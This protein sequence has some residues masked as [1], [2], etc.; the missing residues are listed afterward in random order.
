MIP[1]YDATPEP[2]SFL[3]GPR[4][5]GPAIDRILH[6]YRES[7]ALITAV[8]LGLF[9]AFGKTGESC[10]G[11]SCTGESCTG[12]SCTGDSTTGVGSTIDE[13]ARHCRISAE[14]CAVLCEVL[15]GSGLLNPHLH[16]GATCYMPTELAAAHLTPHAPYP[17]THWVASEQDKYVGFA[18]LAEALRATPTP[19][20]PARLERRR[21]GID[22]AHLEGLAEVARA[23]APETARIVTALH[24]DRPGLILDAGGG[25]GM[26]AIGVVQHLPGWRAVIVDRPRPAQVAQDNTTRHGLTDRITVHEADLESD[27]LHALL[28][29]DTPGCPGADIAFLF[30]VLGGKPA[31]E[32]HA[33]LH[34]L[35]AAL[36]PGGW[37]LI[38]GNWTDAHRGA[39]SA[40]KHL[41]RPGGRRTLTHERTL[42]L[43]ATTGYDL[44][45]TVA[46][47]GIEA[48]AVIAAR[49][50]LPQIPS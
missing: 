36:R 37:L 23:R 10:T 40:L 29:Q 1:S 22:P 46:G 49:R 5:D 48:N 20:D 39:T 13:L 44:I 15:T 8:R 47:V 50:P 4:P 43:L 28:T 25:H 31:P 14:A 26:D 18:G 45:H 16:S 34:N 42:Q 33:I 6:A 2:T 12:E 27:D 21:L 19:D 7:Q 38:R 11:E 17:L 41:L 32:A 3:D 35:Y 30:M 9:D 24:P